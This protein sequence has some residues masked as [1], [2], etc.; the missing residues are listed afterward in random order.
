MAVSPFFSSDDTVYAIVRSELARS[1]DGGDTFDRLVV[2][3]TQP[4]PMGGVETTPAD[5]NRIYAHGQSGPV[6]RSF[7]A[8][9]SWERADRGLPG[10]VEFLAAS[11][12]DADVVLALAGGVLTRSTDGATS[13][14]IVEE[15]PFITAIAFDPANDARIVIGDGLGG[16]HESTDAGA[17]FTTLATSP[18]T[19]VVSALVVATDGAV[20][21]GTDV[22]ATWRVGPAAAAPTVGGAPDG[23]RV[24]SLVRDGETVRAVSAATG[25]F[26]SDDGGATWQSASM[27]LTTDPQAEEIGAPNFNHLAIADDGTAFVGGF[28]GLFR[29]PAATSTWGEVETTPAASL[30]GIAV[31]PAFAQDGTIAVVSY[32]NGISVSTDGGDTWTDATAGLA[33][34]ADW[35]RGPD[36]YNR[37]FSIEFSPDFERDDR[38]YSGGRGVGFV[39]DDRD[40]PWRTTVPDELI[41]ADEPVGDYWYTAFSPAYPDDPTIVLA[42]H[43]GKVLVSTDYGATFARR[44]DLEQA[45]T[46]LALSTTFDQDQTLAVGTDDGVRV[47]VDGGS[48]WEPAAGIPDGTVI[49]SLVAPAGSASA[50]WIAGTSTGLYQSSASGFSPIGVDT[51]DAAAD[52]LTVAVSPAFADDATLLITVRGRGLFQSLDGGAT[53][54]SI[55]PG[56]LDDQHLLT[57]AFRSAA[58]PVAFSPAYAEDG[59]IFGI[60][61]VNVFRSTDRGASWTTIDVPVNTHSTDPADAPAP[62]VQL[63]SV[64][65]GLEA[66]GIPLDRPGDGDPPSSSTVTPESEEPSGQEADAAAPEDADPNDSGGA[67]S[68]WIAI[69]VVAAALVAAAT[70]GLRRRR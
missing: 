6:Y 62:F 43:R 1:T 44:A 24:T 69:G 61:G 53:F 54:A 41:D 45:V 35:E 4:G 14:S 64:A 57:P 32:L 51:V 47:S 17:T 52:V 19:G 48:S 22:G 49:R 29:A 28:D 34:E 13:W 9:E 12:H 58:S 31:S 33:L 2:G 10:G 67:T 55:S 5:G 56:L 38:L 39:S 65:G 11:P 15:P 3:I 68:R 60:S 8:G 36:R 46:S 50:T 42:S 16:V 59:T 66:G 21:V 40:E 37:L 63:P 23:S 7:D 25:V 27:G 30:V 18:E 70:L 20:V 26:R